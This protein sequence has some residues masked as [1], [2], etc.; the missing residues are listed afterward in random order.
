MATFSS[1]VLRPSNSI[2]SR[3]RI[4]F[5]ERTFEKAML[6][7]GIV[8]RQPLEGILG[9]DADFEIARGFGEIGIAAAKGAAQEIGRKQQ[10]DDLLAPVGGGLGQLDRAG[11]DI[12]KERG[13]L[14]IRHD[15]LAGRYFAAMCDGA[16]LG[17][18]VVIHRTADGAVPYRALSA[19]LQGLG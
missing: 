19:A 7:F 4:E 17:K 12:G 6:E 1:A 15:D 10:S 13:W 3:G 16:E 18:L 11:N 14:L 5:I 2:H 8:A 9:K